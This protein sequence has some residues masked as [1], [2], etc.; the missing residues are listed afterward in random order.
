MIKSIVL[1]GG[2]GHCKSVIDILSIT[3]QFEIFGIIDG[4]SSKRGHLVLGHKIIG[5]DAELKE[6]FNHTQ[7]FII[8]VGQITNLFLRQKLFEYAINSGGTPVSVFSNR[9]YISKFSELAQ[10][11]SVGH[12]ATIN[13]GCRIGHNTII[14]NSTLIEHDVN[15][16]KHCHIATS[17]TL[18]GD[19]VVGDNVFIGSNVTVIQGVS[20]CSKSI[21]GAGS[22]VTKD[23]TESGTYVGIPAKKI[24]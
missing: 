21:I 16:G 3:N 20:I 13:A 6:I 7:N 2:G 1:I 8:T 9:G 17:S 10:G 18:N 12:F 19:V 23:I 22:L 14:N 5:S 4:D 11:V 15:I 24:K